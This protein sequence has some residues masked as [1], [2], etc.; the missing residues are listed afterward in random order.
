LERTKKFLRDPN[1]LERQLC[2][3]TQAVK[4]GSDLCSSLANEE[5]DAQTRFT[6]HASFSIDEC[7]PTQVPL[8]SP[9][10][11]FLVSEYD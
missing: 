9:E 4:Q 3:E 11:L 5:G 8:H 7:D 2:S 1:G 6:M 10:E